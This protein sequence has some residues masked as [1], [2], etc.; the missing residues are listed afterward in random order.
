MPK[1][2][3]HRGASKRFRTTASGLVKRRRANRNHILTKK[4]K[5]Q[6]RQLRVTSC[7]LKQ[8]DARLAKRM[9][10]GS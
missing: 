4:T 9:L 8:C 1:L 7:I 6:K 5:K 2:K 3:A 10:H